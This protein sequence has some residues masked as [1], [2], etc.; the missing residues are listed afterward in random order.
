VDIPQQSTSFLDISNLSRT[1]YFQTIKVCQ[2][3]SRIYNCLATAN[4]QNHITFNYFL[5]KQMKPQNTYVTESLILSSL[6]VNTMPRASARPELVRI[7]EAKPDAGVSPPP[8]ATDCANCDELELSATYAYSRYPDS[9][10]MKFRPIRPVNL[11]S[12]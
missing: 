2:I 1:I 5:L 8:L 4:N 9:R 10:V 12:M 7:P 6:D 11:P 3:S